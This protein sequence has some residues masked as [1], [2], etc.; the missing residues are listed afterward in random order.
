MPP[1]P[2]HSRERGNPEGTGARISLRC[3]EIE[4]LADLYVEGE[5]SEES[6]ARI[7]RHLFRC[8]DCSYR[9]RS[10]EQT[11]GLLRDAAPKRES[12]PG[13][14]ERMSARLHAEFA[15]HLTLEPADLPGQLALP[16]FR[17]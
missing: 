14:R 6:T 17:P 9:I 1:T 8:P 7:S 10:I 11:R 2:R 12:N 15:E 4:E 16:D 13:F 3:E 5:L